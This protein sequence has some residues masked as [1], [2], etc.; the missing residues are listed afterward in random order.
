MNDLCQ[1][2]AQRLRE[3]LSG[4]W[5]KQVVAGR[6][7]NGD[8]VFVYASNMTEATNRV[9]RLEP[10]CRVVFRKWMRNKA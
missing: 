8:V 2:E 9:Q 3:G 4:S 10:Q 6:Y 5:L 1:Q 7:E